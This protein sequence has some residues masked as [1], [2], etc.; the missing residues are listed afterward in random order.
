MDIGASDPNLMQAATWLEGLL[1]KYDLPH[2]WHMFTGEHE[3]E[4]WQAHVEDYLR[5]Y[6]KDW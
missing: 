3:E 4:Y 6:T 2:E 5:W 1:T